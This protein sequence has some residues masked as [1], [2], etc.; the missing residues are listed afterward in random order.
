MR[1]SRS[2]PRCIPALLLAVWLPDAAA[3]EEAPEPALRAVLFYN[4]LK[5]ADLPA[6]GSSDQVLNICVAARDPELLT[7][8]GRLRERPLRSRRLAVRAYEA[9]ADCDA[10][11]VE[12][13]ARW[14][15]IVNGAGA[16]G[17][18]TVGAYAG[19]V[20]DGGIIELS[21][22]RDRSRFDI[23]LVAARQAGIRLYPQLLRLA[24]RLID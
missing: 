15:A 19:F 8:M 6:N 20:D 11:Y 9:A 12:S 3:T 18:L 23:N 2:F 5:F 7:A 16:P 14:Q 13:R 10:I 21:F 22:D 4:F 24:R 1:L 17:A